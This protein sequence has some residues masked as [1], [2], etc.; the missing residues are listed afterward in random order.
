M[1]VVLDASGR[2][3]HEE[4]VYAKGGQ[5]PNATLIRAQAIIAPTRRTQSARWPQR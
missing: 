4:P 3:L 5:E 1:I 2:K